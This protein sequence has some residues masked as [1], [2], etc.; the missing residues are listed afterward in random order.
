MGGASGPGAQAVASAS[1]LAAGR[2][3]CE[4]QVVPERSRER[5]SVHRRR[6]VGLER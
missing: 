5:R 3:G 4:K 6:V 1:Q 2:G